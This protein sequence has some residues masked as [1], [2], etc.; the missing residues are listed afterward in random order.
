MNDIFLDTNLAHKLI[1][2]MEQEYKEFYNWLIND[3]VLVISNYLE[4]E[5]CAGNQ[6][7]VS[8]IYK[9][10]I[11]G[12]INRIP[13]SALKSLNFSKRIESHFISNFKDRIHIKT[14]ILSDRKLGIIADKNLVYDI[15]NLP[16]INKIKPIAGTRP[17][18]V[19]YD[20]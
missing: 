8:V 3:G 20:S 15:N 11:Q 1:N 7:L 16:K 19:P 18:E 2:P 9:L 13:N 14:I 17:N 6:N 12:R 10:T 5:Y 4:H